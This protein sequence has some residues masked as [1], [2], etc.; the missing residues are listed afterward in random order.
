MWLLIFRQYGELLSTRGPEI[1]GSYEFR[2]V[3][4]V[5]ENV[6]QLARQ[7]TYDNL[8]SDSLNDYGPVYNESKVQIDTNRSEND[9]VCR[10]H[11][12]LHP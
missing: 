5:P 12:I 4:S 11:K 6:L 3:H 9:D 1:G 8:S 2:M 10:G 7:P